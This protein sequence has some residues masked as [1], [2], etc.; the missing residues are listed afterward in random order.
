ML[1][2]VIPSNEDDPAAHYRTLLR[3]L[4]AYSPEL[5][6]KPRLVAL[7]K[8]D[9]LPPD[10]HDAF[11]AEASAGF[12]DDVQIL[13]ISSVAQKGLDRLKEAL[14]KWVDQQEETK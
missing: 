12:E 13:P 5:M 1:L 8:T 11:V 10:M 9:L 3:E 6:D 4:E 14:W 7:S 2:F